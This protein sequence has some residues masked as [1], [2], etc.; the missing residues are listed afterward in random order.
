MLEFSEGK[1]LMSH[2]HSI[3]R[4]PPCVICKLFKYLRV[5]PFLEKDTTMTVAGGVVE[6]ENDDRPVDVAPRPIGMKRAKKLR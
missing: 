5:Y 6:A 3:I 2:F 1:A 4:N